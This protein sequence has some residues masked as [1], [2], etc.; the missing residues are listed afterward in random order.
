MV[1]L[2]TKNS[3]F[4]YFGGEN[5]EKLSSCL[6]ISTVKFVKFQKFAKKRQYLNLGTK[7][8]YWGFLTENAS[9]RYFWAR[10]KKHDCHILNQDPQICLLAKFFKKAK[11]SK[12]VNKNACFGC[13]WI[14]I[15]KQY[16]HHW[17]KHPQICITAKFRSKKNA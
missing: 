3:L 15:G 14:G 11:M 1:Q 4:D 8:P 17:N 13:F 16:C 10:F 2:T 9:S 5:I 7:M 12:F 6:E